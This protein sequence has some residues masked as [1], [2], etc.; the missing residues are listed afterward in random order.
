MSTRVALITGGSRGIGLATALRFAR[1][2]YTVAITSRNGADLRQAAEQIQAA[3]GT[4]ETVVA[5]V[6]QLGDC[7][8]LVDATVERC[9]RIDVLVNNAGYAPVVPV[10]EMSD[11]DYR[12]T[13]AV[14]VDAVFYL[15]R[16]VWP[17]MQKQGGGVIVNISSRAAFDPFPGFAV[18]GPAKAFVNVFTQAVAKAGKPENIRLYAVAPSMTDTK[19]LRD[20]FPNAPDDQMLDPDDIAKVVESLAGD[21]FAHSVG[22]CISVAK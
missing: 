12:Q 9:G 19:M 4:C 8:K 3:G 17:I 6:G 15:T 11:E 10:A 22:E 21:T 16:A 5:D 7:R 14:N 13:I 20:A 18:Y 1:Q 2:G